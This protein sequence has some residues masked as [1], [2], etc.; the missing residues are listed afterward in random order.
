MSERSPAQ[1]EASKRNGALSQGS[2]TEEG[3]AISSR[4]NTRHGMLATSIVIEGESHEEFQKLVDSMLIEWKP[5]NFDECALLEAMAVARWRQ[6]RAWSLATAGHNHAIHGQAE[7]APEVAGLDMPT[8]A[9]LA[10]CSTDQNGT[11]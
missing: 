10:L 5:A 11:P 8:R 6:M 3:K 2:V 9:W 7:E 4:N 1:I